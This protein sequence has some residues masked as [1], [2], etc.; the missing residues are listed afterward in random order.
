M[1]VHPTAWAAA[2]AADSMVPTK[3]VRLATTPAPDDRPMLL[4][5]VRTRGQPHET[6]GPGAV[7]IIPSDR[8]Q[9]S[10]RHSHNLTTECSRYRNRPA[11]RLDPDDASVALAVAAL[12]L[13]CRR[14]ILVPQVT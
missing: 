6:P 5:T 8:L 13:L 4:T 3:A 2:G 9:R 11:I 1:S 12:V 10:I 7:R 14:F